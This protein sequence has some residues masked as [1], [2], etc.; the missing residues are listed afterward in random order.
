MTKQEETLQVTS[1]SH[2]FL[3]LALVRPTSHNDIGGLGLYPE[4]SSHK[5]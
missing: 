3:Y 4:D 5:M 1:Q 2:L